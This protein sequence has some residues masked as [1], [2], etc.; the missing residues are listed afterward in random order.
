MDLLTYQQ[1]AIITNKWLTEDEN[2]VATLRNKKEAKLWVT[3]REAPAYACSL[4]IA[5]MCMGMSSELNELYD[6]VESK[7]RTGVKEELGD[8]MWY[9]VN[10]ASMRVVSITVQY[11]VGVYEYKHLVHAISKLVDIEKKLII[12][13]K[14]QED[15]VDEEIAA[16]NRIIEICANFQFSNS[17]AK[18]MLP[19][20]LDVNINKLQKVR[21]KLGYTDEAALN[22]NLEAERKELEK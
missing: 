13:N 15:F 17:Y 7:D 2:L 1:K 21:Y 8:V 9:V 19:E 11:D 20:I 3:P 14:P 22:R 10:L 16:I 18:L 6:A 12:Y 4:D 5:H